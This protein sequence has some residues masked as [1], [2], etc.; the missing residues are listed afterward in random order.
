MR[1]RHDG[2]PVCAA[3]RQPF[4]MNV[5]REW[6]VRM[7][8]LEEECGE[9]SVIGPPSSD[10]P[11][12]LCPECGP[13]VSINEDDGSCVACGAQAYP[14]PTYL[15][16]LHQAVAVPGERHNEVRSTQDPKAQESKP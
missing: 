10:V 9:I 4:R 5:A 13:N 2:V 16:R 8:K 6:I 1:H 14:P 3:D 11:T 7:A 12:S 15:L